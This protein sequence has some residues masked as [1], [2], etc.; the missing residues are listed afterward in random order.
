MNTPTWKVL[1]WPNRPAETTS[2]PMGCECGLEAELPCAPLVGGTLSAITNERGLLFEPPDFEPPD[3][4]IPTRVQ[5]RK[6][7][8]TLVQETIEPEGKPNVW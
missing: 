5:C 7:G 8:R 4:W 6:C 2:F 3:G 1:E